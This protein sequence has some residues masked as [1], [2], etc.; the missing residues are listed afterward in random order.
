MQS[1]HVVNG[2]LAE[3]INVKDLLYRKRLVLTLV[4]P[5]LLADGLPS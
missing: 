1:C 5:T 4:F 3:I 2:N